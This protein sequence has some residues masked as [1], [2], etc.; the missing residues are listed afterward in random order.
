V[1]FNKASSNSEQEVLQRPIIKT[2][3]V[4]HKTHLAQQYAV[5]NVV[6]AFVVE[7]ILK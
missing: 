5:V 4:A 1:R 6:P 2:G 7:A 3:S